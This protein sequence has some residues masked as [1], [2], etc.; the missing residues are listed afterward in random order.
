MNMKVSSLHKHHI[1]VCICT[2]KRPEYLIRLVIELEKQK[3][4]G[5]FDYSIIIVDNDSAQSA[6]LPVAQFMKKS[7]LSI[8]YF[9]QPEQNIALTRNKAIE[10]SKGD[11]VGFI[12]DDEFPVENWL[13]E[14]YKA[15]HNFKADGILGPVLPDYEKVPPKWVLK[16][17]FFDRPSHQTGFI[18]SWNDTRTGNALLKRDLFN[19]PRQWF[20][21]KHG[22]GGEDK[23]FFR[24]EIDDGH[25]F[26]WCNE[27]PVY[28]TVPPVR[29]KRTFIIKKAILRGKVF[30]ETFPNRPFQ[31]LKALLAVTVYTI[32]LPFL[33]ICGHHIFMTYLEKDCYHIG[34]ILTALGFNL[35]KQKYVTH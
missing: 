31:I 9:V 2:Y 33:L 29:W 24:K 8:D 11:F 30:Y 13:L 32:S 28:E 20:D 34:T 15:I 7:N 26:V 17:H 25:V 4:E 5:L 19:E 10:N 27:A 18:L 22:S 21:P 3:T 23:D 6:K 12:D 14:H 1:C 35:V 16:G